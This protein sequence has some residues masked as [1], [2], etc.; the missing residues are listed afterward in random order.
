MTTR[1]LTTVQPVALPALTR[2][3]MSAPLLIRS[4][5]RR[6]EDR[7]VDE[8]DHRHGQEDQ[9][10][11]RRTQPEVERLEQVVVAE[12]RHRSGAVGAA[13]E[14]VDV[15]EDPERVEGAEQKRDQDRR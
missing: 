7:D 15:V 14:Y 1:M 11:D 5:C 9:H 12:D 2:S 4:W 6:A 10:A 8:R 13:G 3:V